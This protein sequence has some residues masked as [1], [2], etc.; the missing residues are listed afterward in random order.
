MRTKRGKKRRRE[1][2]LKTQK[3]NADAA[4][5]F[6]PS[7]ELQ[8]RSFEHNKSKHIEKK[9][10]SQRESV[11]M[12]SER[13]RQIAQARQ[14]DE[15][16]TFLIKAGVKVVKRNPIKVSM[17]LLGLLLCL[18]FN[19]WA[20]SEVQQVEF[21]KELEKIDYDKLVQLEHDV[22]RAY[23]PY[24][25]SK[26]WFSCD[27][28]CQSHKAHYELLLDELN[29]LRRNEKEQLSR[30][31]SNLGLFSEYGVEETRNL[32]WERFAQGKGFASRQSKWDAIFMGIG[33]MSRDEGLLAYLVRLG[34]SMLFNFT[35]GVCGAVVAFVF[36]LYYLIQTYQASLV[37]ATT[38][39]AL[40]SLAAVAFALTW[41]IGLYIAAAGTAYVGLKFVASNM[42]IENGG[43]QRTYRVH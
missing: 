6:W 1:E 26:G 22:S 29:D 11:F 33:A 16:S 4:L 28:T 25:R 13:D 31:K 24:Y 37:A 38:Y 18:F 14:L 35:I 3:K 32:F 40:A 9:K 17:Y 41:L 19:G 7:R 20:V 43:A 15:A 39:F 42:R 10:E 5:E 34:V 8:R 12:S 2:K 27:A 23:V 30:A 21:S 36:S